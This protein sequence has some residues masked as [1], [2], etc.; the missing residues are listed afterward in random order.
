MKEAYYLF[1]SGRLS[2]KDNSLCFIPIHNG[3][4]EAPK[5]IP[6]ETVDTIYCLGSLDA[7]SALFHFLGKQNISLHFFD[8]YEHYTGSFLPKD[9]SI[10]G[11]LV[12]Q[13]VEHYTKSRKRMIIAQ[14]FLEAAGFNM[15]KNLKYYNNRDKDTS[16]IILVIEQLL[17]RIPHTSSIDE[18]MGIEGNIR[19]N[20]Y[21]AFD[22]IINDFDMGARTKQPPTNEVNAMI[23]FSNMLCYTLCLDAIYNTQLDPTI[24]FL[25]QPGA[26]RHS[27]ALD[28]AEVFKPILVDRMIFALLNKKQVQKNDFQWTDGACLLGDTGRKIV[29]STWNNRL[30]ETFAH[31]SLNR[32]VSYKTLVKMECY[33]LCRHISGEGVYEGFKAWW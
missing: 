6:V 8:Y 4:E 7:N 21:R 31:R 32:S 29:V 25:H 15:L 27:L 22:I 20:Y 10:A 26:R 11:Q 1:N 3:I 19:L 24:S 33:N 28:I 2:R 13:Q 23:S 9:T 17:N 16:A 5:H 30:K 18:L 12:V 14:R